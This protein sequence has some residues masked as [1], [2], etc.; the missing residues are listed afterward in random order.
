MAKAPLIIPPSGQSFCFPENEK[1]PVC[2]EQ[3][4]TTRPSS[5]QED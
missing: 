3:V 5:Y 1:S 4:A 2:L